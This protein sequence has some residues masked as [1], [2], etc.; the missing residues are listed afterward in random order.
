MFSPLKKYLW[1]KF[2]KSYRYSLTLKVSVTTEANDIPI[3]FFF[4]R[5]NDWK[6]H[7]YLKDRHFTW[8]GKSYFLK[9]HMSQRTKKPT[10]RAISQRRLR[11]ACASA[12]SDQR[13]RW[14]HVPST[15]SGLFRRIN[16]NP[17]HTGWMYGLLWVFAGH[18]GSI[19]RWFL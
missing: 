9:N 14:S 3:F 11:S 18:T 19:V 12:Q 8:K 2:S 16:E 1:H 17:C 10:G 4:P 13:L 15:S 7:V 5:N 6:F